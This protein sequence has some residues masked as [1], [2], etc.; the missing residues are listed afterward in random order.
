[1]EVAL[2]F[3]LPKYGVC[4]ALCPGD[5]IIFNPLEYHCIS[6]RTECYK[7]EWIVVTSFYLKAKQ[8]GLNDNVI[9]VEIYFIDNLQS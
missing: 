8:L 6:Q 1:M 3:C 7:N 9:P 4:I 2:Y 5:I